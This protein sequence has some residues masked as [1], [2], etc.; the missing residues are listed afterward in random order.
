[1]QHALSTPFQLRASRRRK[2]P[3]AA[4]AEETSQDLNLPPEAQRDTRDRSRTRPSI[5]S[6]MQERPSRSDKSARMLHRAMKK[7]GSEM[8]S[9][10]DRV[11]QSRPST[12][13]DR[14]RRTPCRE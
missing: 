13:T 1:M 8:E 9:S 2:D 14:L 4:V 10:A 5:Q 7:R 3:R 11:R 6:S 12:P